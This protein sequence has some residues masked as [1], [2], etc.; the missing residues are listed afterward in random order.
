GGET[1]VDGADNNDALR[2]TRL[3]ITAAKFVTKADQVQIQLGTD[4]SVRN[5]PK[6]SLLAG[7]RYA[8]IF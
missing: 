1:S 7:L 8:H 6:N 4:L 3:R 2:T 5:G